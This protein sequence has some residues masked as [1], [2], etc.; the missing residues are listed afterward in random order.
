MNQGRD[1][2]QLSFY[3]INSDN[4]W[5]IRNFQFLNAIYAGANWLH[6]RCCFI[7]PPNVYHVLCPGRFQIY[8]AAID[9][10][11]SFEGKLRRNEA[12]SN[13]L[14]KYSKAIKSD[15]LWPDAWKMTINIRDLTPNNFNLY[16]EYYQNGLNTT[17]VAKLEK[18]MG[19]GDIVNQ[20]KEV[21]SE[22][23]SNTKR[24]LEVAGQ[25]VGTAGG[26]ISESVTNMFK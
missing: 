23:A 9:V 12:V 25:A 7:R 11:V 2:I 10:T 18:V 1:P 13:E 16:A 17:E 5:L 22:I 14:R 26:K 6:L 15:M 3:L 24:A 8:W 21:F 4:N 19:I 20:A